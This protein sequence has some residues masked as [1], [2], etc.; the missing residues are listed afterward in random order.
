MAGVLT[1]GL[2]GCEDLLDSTDYTSSN[3]ANFPT[4]E[5]DAEMLVTSMYANLNH[6]TSKAE[7]THFLITLMA[8]DDILGGNSQAL[9]KFLISGDSSFDQLWKYHYKGVYLANTAIEGLI[10]L[11]GEEGN[12]AQ[13]Q[14][15]GEAYFMRAFYFSELA[16]IFGGIPLRTSTTQESNL[17]RSSADEVYAQIGDDLVK[18]ISLMSSKPYNAFVSGGHATKWSAEALL[19]RNFLFYTGF[20]GKDSIPA[21][22]GGSPISKQDV[23]G[24]I[25]DCVDNSGHDLV[26]DF[27]NLWAYTNPYTVNDYAYTAGV[28]GVDGQPLN[29]AGNSNC[30][31]VF[32]VKYCNFCGYAT[33]GQEGYSNFFV[34]FFGF[35]GAN[36]AEKTFPFGNGNGFCT[37]AQ[38]LWDDWAAEEPDDLRRQASILNVNDE[39]PVDKMTSNT[40]TGQMED[41]GLRNKKMMPVLAKAAMESQG[42]WANA[43]YWACY[44]DFDKANNYGMTQ[45]G[46]NFNDLMLIRFA[47]VLLMQSELMANAD[48][49]NRVRAR[50]GLPAVGYSLDAL[51]KERRHEL[52]CE[53]TRWNDIRRWGIAADALDAQNGATMNNSGRIVKM[54]KAPYRARYAATKGFYPVPIRQIQLSDNVL[55]QN[56][57]WDGPDARMTAWNFD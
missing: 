32:S 13:K 17:P 25:N 47:D 54:T 31:E 28:T 16:E 24:Y 15:L 19:A 55:T 11:F 50:A 39:L 46:G 35:P 14:M 9:D 36:D 22:E 41:C 26:G 43:I 23:I 3:T 33:E 6:A 38:N 48:G 57:G 29:W 42:S 53:P 7:S 2:T 37:V 51:Q 30:E 56:E 12:E 5:T 18:A 1:L 45:W 52:A 44:P 49:I 8:S 20:Y 21:L 34:P 40:I 4:T 27:R 10:S